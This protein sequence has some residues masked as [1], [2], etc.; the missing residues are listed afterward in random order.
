MESR[1]KYAGFSCAQQD[2]MCVNHDHCQTWWKVEQMAKRAPGVDH[3]RIE[4]IKARERVREMEAA[5]KPEDLEAANRK[6]ASLEA[7]VLV[8]NQATVEAKKL[9]RSAAAK[10]ASVCGRLKIAEAKIE[11]QLDLIA[12]AEREHAE[13]VAART[14]LKTLEAVT[15][16]RDTAVQRTQKMDREL[17]PLRRMHKTVRSMIRRSDQLAANPMA[18]NADVGKFTVYVRGI[19]G[20]LKRDL[21]SGGGV[22]TQEPEEATTSQ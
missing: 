15:V 5:C 6:A 14:M 13:L 11:G 10:H 1:R 20:D 22:S 3:F 21:N 18:T 4:L 8:E 9:A 19:L 17:A 16:E 7:A 2:H 12:Q